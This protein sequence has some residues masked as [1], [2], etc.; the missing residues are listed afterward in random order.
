MR[1]KCMLVKNCQIGGQYRFDGEILMVPVEKLD[2]SIMRRIDG[3]EMPTPEFIEERKKEA[4]EKVKAKAELRRANKDS[5]G[6]SLITTAGQ[7]DPD[8]EKDVSTG[9]EL[10]LAELKEK[11]ALLTAELDA[12]KANSIETN[13]KLIE[14]NA[15]LQAAEKPE[16]EKVL[17]PA[18]KRKITM[19]NKAAA[20]KTAEESGTEE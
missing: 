4:L 2:P 7:F 11:N 1:I 8:E 19:D 9:T 13:G 17:T 5:S 15:K 6:L 20:L 10:E 14:A 12:E 16:T 18:E 3:R